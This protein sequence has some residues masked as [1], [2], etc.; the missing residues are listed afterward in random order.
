M[1]GVKD[2]TIRELQSR[3]IPL[4]LASESNPRF[5]RNTKP[6][7][8]AY[9]KK[10]KFVVIP[11]SIEQLQSVVDIFRKSKPLDFA[12]R[13]RGCGS[14]SAADAIISLSASA[15]QH[16]EVISRDERDSVIV[17][18]GAGTEWG[19]VDRKI[20]ELAPEYV[21][22]YVTSQSSRPDNVFSGIYDASAARKDMLNLSSRWCPMSLRW[23]SWQ[24]TYRRLLLAIA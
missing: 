1:A 15:F 13:G 3:G 7:S 16:V 2:S 5:E 22:K 14:S 9:D 24:H 20:E 17:E 10:P 23:C 11:E 18:V 8:L 21:G 19:D 4:I 12:V 6:W